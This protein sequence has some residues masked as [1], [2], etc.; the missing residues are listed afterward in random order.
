MRYNNL[1]NFFFKVNQVP[2]NPIPIPTPKDIGTSELKI[3]PDGKKFIE[4]GIKCP[5]LS[6]T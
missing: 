4:P 2:I 6:S 5:N 1:L 3:L